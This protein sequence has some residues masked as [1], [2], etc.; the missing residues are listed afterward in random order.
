[1]RLQTGSVV[2]VDGTKVKANAEKS[3]RM[4]ED[5]MEAVDAKLD[6]YLSSS[7]EQDSYDELSE[8]VKKTQVT[9]IYICLSSVKIVKKPTAFAKN[10]LTCQ[11][12]QPPGRE[13]RL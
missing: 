4:L 2:A 10:R 8:A 9:T 6:S 3:L 5:R 1:V 12:K 13:K 7:D 11:K